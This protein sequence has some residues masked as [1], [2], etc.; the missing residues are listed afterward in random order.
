[1]KAQ[2]TPAPKYSGSGANRKIEFAKQPYIGLGQPFDRGIWCAGR[3]Q[4]SICTRA[5]SHCHRQG[6]S[7]SWQTKIATCSCHFVSIGQPDSLAS[8]STPPGLE[9][10]FA[11]RP[12][13]SNS[14][15]PIWARRS[16]ATPQPSFD[17]HKGID[18]AAPVARRSWLAP[19]QPQR[20]RGQPFKSVSGSRPIRRPIRPARY[21]LSDAATWMHSARCA[22]MQQERLALR[23]QRHFTLND[24]NKLFTCSRSESR[25]CFTRVTEFFE[26]T[27]TRLHPAHGQR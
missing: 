2:R 25:S 7:C 8:R 27:E 9:H 26:L 10:P 1:L 18:T 16:V 17:R 20:C 22:P 14:P 5:A 3:G 6:T 13:N 19:I 11:F 15:V 21:S 24:I 12:C 23:S 4:F